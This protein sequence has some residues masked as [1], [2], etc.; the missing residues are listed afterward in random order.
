M[1]KNVFFRAALD[2]QYWHFSDTEDFTSRLYGRKLCGL[3]II[4]HQYGL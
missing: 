2:M 4:F 1:R 3:E